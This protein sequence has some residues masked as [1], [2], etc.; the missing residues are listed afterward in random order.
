MNALLT[1]RPSLSPN[2]GEYKSGSDGTRA[3]F[4]QQA[5]DSTWLLQQQKKCFTQSYAE[6]LRKSE[7]FTT[8]FLSSH[9]ETILN[10]FH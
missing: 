7:S 4:V 8:E 5:Q 2:N 9:A 1:L 10:N 6:S 3:Y